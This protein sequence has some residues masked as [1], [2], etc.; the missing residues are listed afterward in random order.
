MS[1]EEARRRVEAIAEKHATELARLEGRNRELRGRLL[2]STYDNTK[3][4]RDVAD[5]S[6]RQFFLEKVSSP[7]TYLSVW[8]VL[9]PCTRR[10]R[11]MSLLTFL[12]PRKNDRKV[13][14][15]RFVFFE[16]NNRKPKIILGRFSEAD[17]RKPN[18]MFGRSSDNQ[19]NRKRASVPN[20]STATV[21]KGGVI[22]IIRFW[23]HPTILEPPGNSFTRRGNPGVV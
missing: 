6:S 1:Q 18:T 17:L 19:P 22:V 3:R 7:P 12:L 4:L 8:I 5:L 20:S 13:L 10:R 16:N 23:S 15:L 21:K 2:E 11:G 9:A 14:D